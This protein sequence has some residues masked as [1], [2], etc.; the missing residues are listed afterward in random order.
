MAQPLVQ[1]DFPTKEDLEKHQKML[2]SVLEKVKKLLEDMDAMKKV[3]KLFA[4]HLL[5]KITI[6]DIL[7][8][9]DIAGDLWTSEQLYYEALSVTKKGKMIILKRTVQEMWV[10]N[11]N[12][13]C[14]LAWN[15]N[16]D[17]Q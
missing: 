17:I 14:L 8:Y 7:I 1:E 13:E 16:M 6:D 10:N 5:E 11:Y 15:G 4:Q 2:Q 12:P 3:D 9:A